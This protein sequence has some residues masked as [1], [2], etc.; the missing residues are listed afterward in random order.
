MAT[1]DQ[2]TGQLKPDFALESP[3]QPGVIPERVIAELRRAR[4]TAKDYATAYSEA[5]KAQAEKH[6]IRPR[7]LKAYIAA[8]EDDSLAE[9]DAET[10]DL[11]RLL[12]AP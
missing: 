9:L 5:A 4:A 3:P 6:G 8:L 2:E 12:D 11:E 7:A 1:V 10:Q